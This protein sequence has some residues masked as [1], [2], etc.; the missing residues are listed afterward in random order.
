[1]GVMRASISVMSFDIVVRGSSRGVGRGVI[2]VDI[3]VRSS[4]RGVRVLADV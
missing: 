3:V 4:R 1:M 2:G